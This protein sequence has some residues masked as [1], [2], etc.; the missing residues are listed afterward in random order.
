M[1]AAPAAALAAAALAGGLVGAVCCGTTTGGSQGGAATPPLSPLP[2]QDATSQLVL[3]GMRGGGKT[4]NGKA[5]AKALGWAFID[6][7]EVLEAE[8]G[9]NCG[10]Y[11]KKNDWAAF[12]ALEADIL[13]R[14]LRNAPLNGTAYGTPENPA[15]VACGGGV[16]E[17]AANV[18]AL[19]Q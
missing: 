3:I 16:I 7:D 9:M 17:T 12:R 10:E 11:V 14:A 1:D 4:S 19:Q 8:A 2:P 6:L 5:V 18:A 13:N 15:I